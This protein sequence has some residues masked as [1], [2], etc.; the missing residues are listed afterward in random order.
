M[1]SATSKDWKKGRFKFDSTCSHFY[2]FVILTLIHITTISL[3]T[4]VEEC[5]DTY[6][7]S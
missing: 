4:S 5:S 1:R 3:A 2:Q 6:V 7:G